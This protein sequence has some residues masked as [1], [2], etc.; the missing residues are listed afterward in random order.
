LT[1]STG[2]LR[3]SGGVQPRRPGVAGVCPASMAE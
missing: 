2:G 3:M 1:V